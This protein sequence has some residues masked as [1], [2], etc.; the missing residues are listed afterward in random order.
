VDAGRVDRAFAA[1]EQEGD[2][3]GDSQRDAEQDADRPI[4][5]AS[6][7][8]RRRSRRAP[9]GAGAAPTAGKVQLTPGLGNPLPANAR[10][11]PPAVLPFAWVVAAQGS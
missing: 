6:G 3:Y 1:E 7:A 2:D 11:G 5:T 9:V 10:L 8:G 4:E